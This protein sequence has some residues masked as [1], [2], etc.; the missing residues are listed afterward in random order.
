MAVIDTHFI[1]GANRPFLTLGSEEYA[2]PLS[3]G[4]NWNQLRIIL[5]CAIRADGTN[6]IA[7]GGIVLGLCSGLSPYGASNTG[8]FAGVCFGTIGTPLVTYTYNANSGNPYYSA[9]YPQF[10]VRVNGVN[11]IGVQSSSVNPAYASTNVRFIRSCLYISITK[12]SPNFTFNFQ[13][14]NS[15]LMAT[16]ISYT[17]LIEIAEALTLNGSGTGLGSSAVAAAVNEAANGYLD[18]LNIYWPR[19]GTPLELYGIAVA[20]IS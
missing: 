15:G 8:H 20:R 4:T 18:T 5:L 10:L 19:S 11:T 1:S 13:V 17:G 6:N 9:G 16:D 12:G 3:I 14:S 2:R 7:N